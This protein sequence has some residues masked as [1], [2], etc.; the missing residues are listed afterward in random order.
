MLK[1]KQRPFLFSSVLYF[2]YLE[3][4]LGFFGVK[5]SKDE[6]N[7]RYTEYKTSL[8]ILLRAFPRFLFMSSVFFL[9]ISLYFFSYFHPVPLINLRPIFLENLHFSPK[10]FIIIE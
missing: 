8:I 3:Y 7:W 6:A 9:L 4:F 10:N 5:N 1:C 2:A